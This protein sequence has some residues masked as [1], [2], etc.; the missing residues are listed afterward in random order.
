LLKQVEMS[1]A[2]KEKFLAKQEDR[3]LDNEK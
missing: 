3:K 2:D 1:I